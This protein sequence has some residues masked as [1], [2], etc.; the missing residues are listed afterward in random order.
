MAVCPPIWMILYYTSWVQPYVTRDTPRVVYC[1]E[2][3]TS[4][5]QAMHGRAMSMRQK[6]E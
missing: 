2:G 6:R 5:E 1:V 4:H 3:S